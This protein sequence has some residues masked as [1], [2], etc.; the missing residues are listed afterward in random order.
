MKVMHNFE[1]SASQQLRSLLVLAV[2]VPSFGWMLPAT[3]ATVVYDNGSADGSRGWWS[4]FDG[5]LQ[6]FQQMADNF[7]LGAGSNTFTGVSWSGSYY[8]SNNPTAADNFV[9]RIFS[10]LGG[11]PDTNPIYSFN[12]GNAVNRID[13]GIDDATWN[14]DIY[15]YSAS[16]PSTTLTAGTTYWLSVVN[17]TS[18]HTDDWLWE[19][20]QTSGSSAFRLGEGNGWNPHGTELAFQISAVPEPETY[21]M[22]LAGLGLLGFAARRKK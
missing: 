5:A 8:A 12:V 16:V 18:G 17:D 10:D 20:S 19:N 1:K 21:A 4:D 13:S 22:L 11:I 14:I 15:N 3:A 7:V 9:I 2:A 6:P